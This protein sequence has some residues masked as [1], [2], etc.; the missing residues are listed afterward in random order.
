MKSHIEY[1]T[2]SQA[3]DNLAKKPVSNLIR[4]VLASGLAALLL[5]GGFLF[6]LFALAASTLF[7]GVIMLR[8]WWANR[9]MAGY[10]PASPVEKPRQSR[11]IEGEFEV[12]NS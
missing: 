12:H 9:K 8:V 5:I 7:L 11:V 4:L 6:G 3:S 2:I 1:Y 10:T